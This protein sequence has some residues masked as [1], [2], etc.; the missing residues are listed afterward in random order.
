MQKF[1]PLEIVFYN[2]I[3]NLKSMEGW[4]MQKHREDLE[5]LLIEKKESVIIFF[6]TQAGFYK[7]QRKI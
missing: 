7:E 4:E 3:K 2:G 6:N 5:D 1:Q